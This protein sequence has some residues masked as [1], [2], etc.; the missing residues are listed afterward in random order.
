[1]IRF[2]RDQRTMK[3]QIGTLQD[4]FHLLT[5]EDLL[6]QG[7]RRLRD[8]IAS[9]K[10]YGEVIGGSGINA[11]GWVAQQAGE[12]MEWLKGGKAMRVGK[13]VKVEERDQGL[14]TW[15]NVFKLMQER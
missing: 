11:E 2:R 5:S 15:L 6:A 4:R 10:Q 8:A 12:R 9:L 1:M 14:W 13:M 7:G 3:N